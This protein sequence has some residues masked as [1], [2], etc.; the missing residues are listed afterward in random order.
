MLFQVN[1]ASPFKNTAS[2]EARYGDNHFL[3]TIPVCFYS[4][5]PILK[6]TVES[7]CKGKFG[8]HYIVLYKEVSSIKS[9]PEDHLIPKSHLYDSPNENMNKFLQ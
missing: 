5:V 2:S 9:V 7:G 3:E 6:S 1:V 4:N 8:Q